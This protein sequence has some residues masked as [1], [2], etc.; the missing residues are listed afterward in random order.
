MTD[1]TKKSAELNKLTTRDFLQAI[2]PFKRE[3]LLTV[4]IPVS[5]ILNN[6]LLPLYIGKILAALSQHQPTD[7]YVIT[8]IGIAIAGVVTNYIGYNAQFM[9]Q[10]KVMSRLDERVFATLLHRSVGF[11]SNSISGKLITDAIAYINAWQ[12]LSNALMLNVIPFTLNV[13]IGIAIVFSGSWLLGLVVLAMT[14]S[15]IV[16]TIMQTNATKDFR[17]ERHEARREKIAHLSD[18]IINNQTVKIFAGE[19]QEAAH[20]Q[21]L[22]SKLEKLRQRD[23]HR[24]ARDGS[25]RIGV[26]Q[27]FEIIFVLVVIKIVHNDPALLSIGIFTFSYALN[28]GNRLFDI[29]TLFRTVEDAYL[30][31][32]DITKIL[33]EE[34]EIVD[35]PD[36]KDLHVKQGAIELEHVTFSYDETGGNEHIFQGLDLSIDA[37][38]RIGLVGS[39]GGGKST[40]TRLLLRFNDVQAGTISIDKQD[41]AG[42][43]QASLRQALSY[44]PQ[45]PLLFHRS[46][47]DNIAYGKLTA[48]RE[49]VEAAAKQAYAY[50]FIQALPQGFDT[51]VGER[52]VKLSGGQRQRVAIARAILKDAP[53]LLLDEA[54]S[55][56]DSE[57][58]VYIQSAMQKLMEGRT[59]IVIAH[60]LSTIQK[61]D[62]IVVLDNGAIVEQGSHK[63]LLKQK[64]AYAKL[65]AHQSGGF[66]ED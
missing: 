66:I 5:A 30:E 17:Q 29:G 60:R 25:R 52:G 59:A 58:E 23:W 3:A 27:V 20:G 61:M 56:L 39:S 14:T 15:V 42:V 34:P 21:L 31:A 57:S 35:A 22:G 12:Q 40:L 32:G 49:Q 45:E 7:H 11:H 9:L 26:L 65:W 55:A 4:L 46:I 53:I 33:H 19:A 13:A 2:L 6:T 63:E 10:P 28:L 43:T 38:E 8:F 41:I 44:V 50:D 1:H 37:G 48:T 54:T 51:I 62:R 36:A 47:G 18:T 24:Q 64:G 16:V